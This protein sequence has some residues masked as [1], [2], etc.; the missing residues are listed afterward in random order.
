MARVARE[1]RAAARVMHEDLKLKW[2]HYPAFLHFHQ[3]RYRARK[4]IAQDCRRPL[5]NVERGLRFDFNPV[6]YF[7]FSVS[8][9]P[10]IG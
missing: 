5:R 3:Q 8:S 4:P 1:R 7:F 6:V 10:I 2:R 9:T